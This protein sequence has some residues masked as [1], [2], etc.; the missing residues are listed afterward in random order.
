MKKERKA[1]LV[2]EDGSWFKGESVGAPVKRFG[3]VVFNTS[4]TAYQEILTDPSYKGQIVTMTYPLIGNVGANPEDEESRRPFVEGFVVREFRDR[5]SNWRAKESLGDYLRRHEIPAIG[6]IDT[7][8]L[9]LHLRRF[10]VV[11]GV[12]DGTGRGE[13][14]DLLK[15]V[16]T[17]PGLVGRDLVKEVTCAK[18]YTWKEGLWRLHVEKPAETFLPLDEKPR[19][20]IAVL[21]CGV[22]YNILRCLVE[23]G[24]DVEVYPATTLAAELLKP[25][26]AGVFVSNGPGDPQGASYVVETLRAIL[27]RK[28][29]FGICLGHQM[30]ALA[31]GGKTYKMKFGHRGVNQPVLDLSTRKVE[32]T[33]QNHGFA[34][35]LSSLNPEEVETTHINLS[36]ET[37]EGLRFKK[38]PAFSVQYHPEASGGPHDSR[39]LFRRFRKL[40]ETGETDSRW[41]NA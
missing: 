25:H 12:L 39:Y 34:V 33:S 30:L 26:F 8:T 18:P 24:L 19:L 15:E 38:I 27:G 4:M 40:L 6:G 13:V 29:V 37:S 16:K 23:E 36:D 35:D 20:K 41:E 10:G 5:P 28:P 31:A 1:L 7:R 32:I 22:K 17:S 14:R 21:D 9:T 3:E 11:K 2:L